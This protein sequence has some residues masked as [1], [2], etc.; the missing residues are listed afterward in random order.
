MYNKR[1]RLYFTRFLNVCN[2]IFRNIKNKHDIYKGKDVLK[3]FCL[4]SGEHV[5]KII[6]FKKKKI[7]LLTKEQQESYEKA[8]TCYICKESLKINF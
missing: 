7:K 5:M 4:S 8:K 3:N 6:S 1:K 2:I